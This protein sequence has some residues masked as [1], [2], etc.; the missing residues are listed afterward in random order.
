MKENTVV[1]SPDI[2][3]K[4]YNFVG[5]FMRH[6]GLKRYIAVLTQLFFFFFLASCSLRLAILAWLTVLAMLE[7]LSEEFS[8]WMSTSLTLTKRG[9][10]GL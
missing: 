4:Y 1:L 5:D 2:K 8:R 9:G 7:I 3:K 6:P 10:E